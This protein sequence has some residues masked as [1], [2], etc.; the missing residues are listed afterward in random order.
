MYVVFDSAVLVG[1]F[2]LRSIHTQALLAESR[3]GTHRVAIPEVV[4][5]EVTNKWREQ[6]AIFLEK[7]GLQAERYGLRDIQV[8]LPDLEKAATDYRTWLL[9]RLNEHKVLWLDIPDVDHRVLLKSAVEKRKPFSENGA[10]YRDALVWESVKKPALDS[11]AEVYLV[12]HDKGDFTKDDQLHPDL[13]ANLEE[14]G[15]QQDRVVFLYSCKTAVESLMTPARETLESFKSRLEYDTDY[16]DAVANSIVQ[17]LDTSLQVADQG[18]RYGETVRAI[19]GIEL[20][21]DN[22]KP[23]NAWVIGRDLIGV[24]LEVEAQIDVVVDVEASRYPDPVQ[25]FDQ[26][27]P[28]QGAPQSETKTV[29]GLIM[30]QLVLSKN[31]GNAINDAYAQVTSL[32]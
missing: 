24:E 16:R 21:L 1:D 3:D 11:G 2:M 12:S 26:S 18:L 23:L 5:L 20:P 25:V 13:V 28:G 31:Q 15:I 19:E 14:A 32:S 4:F 22:Y 29:K 17:H 9:E 8:N 27:L 6:A 10:G 30:V 7:T